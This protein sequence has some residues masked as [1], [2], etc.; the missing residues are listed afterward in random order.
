MR[1]PNKF[2]RMLQVAAM[3]ALPIGLV[4][5]APEEGEEL[6]TPETTLPDADMDMGAEGQPMTVDIEGLEGSNVSG[7]ATISRV[8][9]SLMV[10]L[11]LENLPAEGPFRAQIVSGMCE[12]RENMMGTPE[13][14]EPGTE[15]GTDPAT[16]PDPATPGQTTGMQG[17][18]LATLEDVQ[19]SGATGTDAA[20]QAGM[21]HSTVPVSD[22][23]GQTQ[24]HVEIQGQG[25]QAVACGNIDNLGQVLMGTGTGTA[26]PQGQPV[27]PPAEPEEP[28]N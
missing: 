12:D 20:G 10:S 8:G 28:G 27:T 2:T 11:S 6:E 5:C 16:T 22:L 4:S 21:S 25:N 14:T 17:Q 18:V 9:E 13:P 19:V 15:P 23:Q 3:L 24:A 1:K 7:E 26:A